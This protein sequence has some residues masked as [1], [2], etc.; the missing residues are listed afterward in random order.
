VRSCSRVTDYLFLKLLPKY[1]WSR[2]V[3][4]IITKKHIYMYATIVVGMDVEKT[5]ATA[6]MTTT[7]DNDY[8]FWIRWNLC[9]RTLHIMFYIVYFINAW[10]TEWFTKHVHPQFSLFVMYLFKFQ[11]LIFLN[12]LDYLSLKIHVSKF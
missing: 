3:Y 4:I 9:V 11:L 8:L 6:T 12:I 1:R 2:Y 5:S 10:N 7:N